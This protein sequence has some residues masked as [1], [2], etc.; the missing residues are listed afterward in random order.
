MFLVECVSTPNTFIESPEGQAT[1]I[2]DVN[3]GTIEPISESM[4]GTENDNISQKVRQE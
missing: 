2:H 4:K 1:H 3:T